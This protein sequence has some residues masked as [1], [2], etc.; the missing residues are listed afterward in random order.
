MPSF[1]LRAVGRSPRLAEAKSILRRLCHF[2]ILW[3]ALLLVHEGGHALVARHE[4]MTVK[5]VTVGVG[6]A[7]WRH[8]GEPALVLRAVPLAGFTHVT[9]A[10]SATR[11]DGSAWSAWVREAATLAGGGA[12]TLLLVIAM[13]GFVRAREQRTRMRCVWARIVIADALVLTAFNLLPV[14]PLDGGRAVIS[15]VAAW[16]GAPLAPEALFWLHLGGLTLAVL[17]LAIWPGWT[18]PIDAAALHWGSPREAPR[19]R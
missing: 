4:G 13:A 16:Q 17:P 2:W 14:P 5:R 12:A 1:H 11:P 10:G 18:R 9:E 15:A 3:S 8:D 7:L 19:E 6:P